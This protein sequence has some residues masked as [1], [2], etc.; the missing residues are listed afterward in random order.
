LK[1]SRF[2]LRPT[3]NLGFLSQTFRAIRLGDPQKYILKVGTEIPQ[4][5]KWAKELH[6]F[7]RELAA[8]QLL[9][10]L[11]GKYSPRLF[12]GISANQGSDGLLL[13]EEIRN[14]RNLDQLRG[15]SWTQ[16]ISAIRTIA[17]IHAYFWNSPTLKKSRGLPRHDYMRAHEVKQN[18]PAFL[19]WA[20]LSP[21]DRALFIKLISQV[22][23]ILARFKK[24]PITLVHGD[25]RSDNVFYE[26]TSVRFI[27]WGLSSIGN[28][29]FDLARFACGS[30]RKPLNLLQHVDLFT[31][32]HRE[33]LRRGVPNYPSQEAW[34]DYRD[35]VLLT[36]TIP[37]TNGPT[38]AKF[39]NRGHKLAKVMT[40]RF[41]FA[42][43]V[44]NHE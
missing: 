44:V 3:T 34:Q 27:D 40:N 21:R 8:Y 23:A 6:V 36:L 38:L 35:A 1:T 14:A 37:V 25:L 28:P 15:L 16:L 22:P 13:L 19:R 7:D 12:A 29:N 43:R 39:S 17:N 26:Q 10:P 18:L 33:L 32:W 31:V 9:A 5:R 42:A 30:A 11:K 2:L 4:R 24:R 20:K 41:I